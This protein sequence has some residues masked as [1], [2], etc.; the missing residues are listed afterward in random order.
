MYMCSLF[1]ILA[2]NRSWVVS[3]LFHDQLLDSLIKERK[4][5]N[6]QASKFVL[7]G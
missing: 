5:Y 3:I 7:N 2:Y 4:H 1:K 6:K